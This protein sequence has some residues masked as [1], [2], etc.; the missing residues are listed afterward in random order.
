MSRPQSI[1]AQTMARFRQRKQL[2]FV[3]RPQRCVP[4]SPTMKNDV[5]VKLYC[6][7]QQV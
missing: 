5:I 7:D 2:L 1:I 6:H 3:L 4:H